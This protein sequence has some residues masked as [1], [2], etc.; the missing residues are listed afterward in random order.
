VGEGIRRAM[1]DNQ[2]IRRQDLFIQTK[3][4]PLAGQDPMNIPFDPQAPPKTQVRLSLS[5]SL[6]LSLPGSW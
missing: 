6:S 5:L 3:F 2:A 1:R 4:T